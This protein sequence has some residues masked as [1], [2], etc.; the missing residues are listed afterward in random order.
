[1]PQVSRNKL[2]NIVYAE[3]LDNL[4]QALV[5]VKKTEEMQVF[6]KDFFTKTERL[7]LAKRLTIALMLSHNY[8]AMTISKFLKVSTATVYKIQNQIERGGPGLRLVIE[9]LLKL[10]KMDAFWKRVNKFLSKWLD[11]PVGYFDYHET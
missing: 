11:K 7:M 6:I 5:E 8:E 4:I 1:M 2:E 10:E 3:I 9:K